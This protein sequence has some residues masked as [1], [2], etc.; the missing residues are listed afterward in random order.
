[1]CISP[2][3]LFV[4]LSAWSGRF[5]VAKTSHILRTL[6]FLIFVSRANVVEV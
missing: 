2:V 5:L 3:L 4:I 1:M 6:F